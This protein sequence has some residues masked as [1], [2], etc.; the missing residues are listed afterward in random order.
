MGQKINPVGFRV[1]VI[2]GYD[3]HWFYGKRGFRQ[4]LLQDYKIR[5]FIRDRIGKG[6]ISRVEIERAANRVKVT[7]FTSRPGA[8]IGKGGKGIDELS[9]Q[10]NHMIRKEDKTMG[11]QVNVTEVRQPEMD[12][13][14]VAENIA[15]QLEKRIS[16]RRAMRQALTRVARMN[17]RGIKIHVAGRLGGS[18]IARSESDMLGKV[19]LHTLRA[20]IDYGIS[21]ANTIYGSVGVKVWIYRGEILPE[22]KLAEAAA[23][24]HREPLMT[25]EAG[26]TNEAPP[27]EASEAAAEQPQER[28]EVPAPAEDS[29]E[30]VSEAAVPEEPK[31]ELKEEPKERSET[32]EEASTH[33][34]A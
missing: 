25:D 13:Q 26:A 30:P 7:I 10:L 14:L 11:V 15:V 2:R 34:D 17:G 24:R 32:Q 27:K 1:G 5:E 6:V 20:D 19:P 9:D 22:R 18:E 21:T 29:S 33:V 3:S 4:A 12:A 23:P 31:E 28:A 16:H 8:I